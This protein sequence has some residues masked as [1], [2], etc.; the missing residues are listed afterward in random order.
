MVYGFWQPAIYPYDY[1]LYLIQA[2][3]LIIFGMYE[4]PDTLQIKPLANHKQNKSFLHHSQ[5]NPHV[6]NVTYLGVELASDLT[7][8]LRINK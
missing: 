4:V 2:L 7:W 5:S 1:R 8:S 3:S 6:D